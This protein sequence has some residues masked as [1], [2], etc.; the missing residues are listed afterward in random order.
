MRAFCWRLAVELIKDAYQVPKGSISKHG[1]N[2]KALQ[3]GKGKSDALILQ[4]LLFK[5]ARLDGSKFVS[6]SEWAA[7]GHP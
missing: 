2:F 6:S 5:W 3:I 1:S 4:C 7:V